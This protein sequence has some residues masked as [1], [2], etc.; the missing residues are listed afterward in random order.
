MH[1]D[2]ENADS[3]LQMKSDLNQ[4][5]LDSLFDLE[6]TPITSKSSAIWEFN[7]Y[8]Q[9]DEPLSRIVSLNHPIEVVLTEEKKVANIRLANAVDK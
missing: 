4:K 5:V 7:I 2:A 3:L 8:I 9:A 6:K 1:E